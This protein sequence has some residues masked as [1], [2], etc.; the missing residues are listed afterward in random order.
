[1][2]EGRFHE[3][4]RQAHALER[5]VLLQKAKEYVNVESDIAIP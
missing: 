2:T 3:P 1:M 5:A 4:D